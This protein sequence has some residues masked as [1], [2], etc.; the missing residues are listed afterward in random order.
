M[1]GPVMM[2]AVFTV[3]FPPD[4]EIGKRSRPRGA[5]PPFFSP[6]R[7][8]CEPWHWHSNHCD[9]M[10]C[11]TR[12]PRGAALWQRARGRAGAARGRGGPSW[13]EGVVSPPSMLVISG[14][15]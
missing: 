10:H 6:L 7:L 15:E 1:G 12:P 2:I 14:G 3:R 11:G 13:W 4:T 5:G 9:G 8:Y